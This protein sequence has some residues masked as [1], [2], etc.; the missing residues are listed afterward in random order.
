[1]IDQQLIFVVFLM[2]YINGIWWKECMKLLEM[3]GMCALFVLL[4]NFSKWALALCANVTFIN[5][6]SFCKSNAS[7]VKLFCTMNAIDVVCMCSVWVYTIWCCAVVGILCGWRLR[8]W[9]FI[10]TNVLLFWYNAFFFISRCLLAIGC[11]N[12]SHS[13]SFSSFI[14]KL[15]G[16]S[17]FTCYSASYNPI[18]GRKSNSFLRSVFLWW[19]P[20]NIG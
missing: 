19:L 18:S 20:F 3:C 15:Q 16:V 1:M 14:I 11:H 9:L 8:W 2:F 5:C 12:I 17:L 13:F 4:S 6:P 10:F 7:Y